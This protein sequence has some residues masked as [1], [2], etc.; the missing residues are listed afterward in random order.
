MVGDGT[1]L[2]LRCE[3][4]SRHVG[5][6][7]VHLQLNAQVQQ[8]TFG[9]GRELG[10]ERRERLAAAVEEQ[11]PGVVR[12]DVVVLL[13]QRGRGELSDLAGELDAGRAGTY[14]REGQPAPS[15]LR[16][17]GRLGHLERPEDPLPDGQRVSH[18][19]HP[20]GV[21][22]E[23]VVTEVGLPHAGRDDQVVVVETDDRA[24]GSLAA[25][26]VVLDVEVLHLGERELDVAVASEQRAERQRDLSLGQ[27]AG[28]AL[29][30]QRLEQMVLRAIDEGD[31]HV[32][33]SQRPGGE[34]PGETP[35]DDD[36]SRCRARAGWH[37]DRPS[38][39]RRVVP[40]LVVG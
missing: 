3:A 1:V 26:L 6:D 25:D 24:A 9:L 11:H 30:E 23:P 22:R 13:A 21:H 37:P 29:V 35:A 17:G 32:A 39:S 34:Q 18:R 8:R 36:D 16:V 15:L 14:Q 33:A 20:G 28:R 7:R 2:P 10:S 40:G 27:D 38:S 5:D 31:R 4:G 12:V 19:L